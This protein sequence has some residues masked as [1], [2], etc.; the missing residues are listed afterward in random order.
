MADM[1]SR[2]DTP[3]QFGFFE[4]RVVPVLMLP[5]Y[6]CYIVICGLRI[7]DNDLLREKCPECSTL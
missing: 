1:A 6:W 4:V 5:Q 3:Y 2:A 7:V